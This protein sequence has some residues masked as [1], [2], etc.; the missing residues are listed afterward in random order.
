[1][2]FWW[3]PR[4]ALTE[5]IARLG[6]VGVGLA[7]HQSVWIATGAVGPVAE[8]DAPEMTFG[9]FLSKLWSAKT[10]ARA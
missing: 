8:L 6:R 10:L 7:G 3:A 9:P 5:P 4:G 2:V 1:M